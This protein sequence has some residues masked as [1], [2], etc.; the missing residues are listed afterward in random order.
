MKKLIA[1]GMVALIFF[2][3]CGD[4]EP[5]EV[6]LVQPA[7][8]DTV[9]GTVA[10]T[11]E[12]TDNKGVTKVEFY[13][14]NI[15]VGADPSSPYS[16]DWNTA[17]LQDN[18]QHN[19]YA[20]AFDR[21]N[22]QGTSAVITVVVLNPPNTP[23]T[24]WGPANGYRGSQYTYEFYSCAADPGG[25]GVA[26]RFSWGD[27][28]TS[29][30]SSYQVSGDTIAMTHSYLS[31]GTFNV[32]AQA[33]DVNGAISGWS[34]A[35][36]IT[37]TAGSSQAPYAPTVNGPASGNPDVSYNF[38]ANATDPDNESVSIR[39]AWGDGDTSNW[40][41]YVS[42]GSP[43]T[44]AHAYSGPG[45]YSIT[46]QARDIH[47]LRSPWSAPHQILIY[48]GGA[49]NPPNTPILTGPASGYVTLVQTFSAT[50]TDPEG[51]NISIRFAWGDG[52]TS[53]W[54]LYV[55]SGG[56]VQDTHTYTATGT[57][58]VRAQARDIQG[59]TSGWSSPQSINVTEGIVITRPNGGETY[60]ADE[61]YPIH[62]NWY[63][64]FPL[65]KIEYS[66][67]GGSSWTTIVSSTDNDGC[68]HWRVPYTSSTFSSCRVRVSHPT[69]LNIYDISDANFTIARDTISVVMPNGGENYYVGEYYPVLWDWTGRFSNVSI[70]YSTDNGS[71]WIPI[72]TS[73]TN[74]GAYAWHVDNA[75]ATTA[76]V[77][78]RNQSDAVLNDAS[79]ANFTIA[80]PQFTITRPNGGETYRSGK[81][82]PIHWD[83]RGRTGT[84]TIAYSTDGGTNWTNI[85]TG[86]TNDG[87]YNWTV[88]NVNS[89]NC[90][91][92]VVSSDDPDAYDISDN[93]FTI[94]NTQISDTIQ[95]TSPMHNDNW[96]LGRDYY[97][98]WAGTFSGTVR[99]DYSTDGGATWNPITSS[100]SG[101]YYLWS[102]NGDFASN[103]C[104][105]KVTS[106][107]NPAIYDESETFTIS[108][109]T[110][111]VTAPRIND[112]WQSG[113]DCY[114]TWDWTGYFS[115]ARIDYSTDNGSTWNTITAGTP[116]D[117]YYLWS[118]PD[119]IANS[120]S[121]VRVGVANTAN[122]GV[123]DRFVIAPQI[124]RVTSP[125]SG[126]VWYSGRNYCITW[127]WTG[128]FSNARID[129]STDG[130]ATWNQIAANADND[131]YYLWTV[132]N[133]SSSNCRIRI[134]NAQN[135]N[136]YGL[137]PVFEIRGGAGR[138]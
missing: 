72:I 87:S 36:Q 60:L 2:I 34:G 63:G 115:T 61:Y 51:Q 32:T 84:V 8:G 111:T 22:N 132:P 33:K 39:F 130:G 90:R 94:T 69:N 41:S 128:D 124:V 104:K 43:I 113:R 129:Y 58:S 66:T 112:S 68:Y 15:L 83:W 53:D 37:V 9:S 38:D 92:R 97:I 21:A 10:I 117:G 134:A 86:A 75:P 65:V 125:M 35:H 67:D 136:A 135:I 107:A 88:P 98:T 17:A 30:W 18:S 40:S 77:R 27:G 138:H 120:D 70:D 122:Y 137:S 57:F 95:V 31:T 45:S 93:N 73:T 108:R 24:P 46:A 6:S 20:K 29:G 76:L 62:W 49:N 131:G 119:D 71:S 116:N 55:A 79:N 80:R 106:T 42:S 48:T 23:A 54:S 11:A 5:P 121:R 105:V 13:V 50:A 81:H 64:S 1:A 109:Q 127:D 118:V 102:V 74:D 78:V 85:V 44:M 96:I 100:T 123:S 126:D 56:T 114:I 103:G 16:H 133:V 19:I 14:D 25:Q 26:V 52:D 82:F 7:N 91:I 101:G 89:S 99:I 4:K 3:G 12:A 28:D 47:G 59:A 110:I